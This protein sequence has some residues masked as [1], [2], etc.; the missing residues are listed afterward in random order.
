MKRP[1][2]AGFAFNGLCDSLWPF[3]TMLSPGPTAGSTRKAPV[4]SVVIAG[5]GSSLSS[6]GGPEDAATGVIRFAVILGGILALSLLGLELQRLW[7][8]NT[9]D[10][11]V[12]TGGSTG[13]LELLVFGCLG[14]AALANYRRRPGV[15]LT[16]GSLLFLA[17]GLM[18]AWFSAKMLTGPMPVGLR[19]TWNSV[20][21]LLFALLVVAPPLLHYAL[22]LFSSLVA[23]LVLAVLIVTGQAGGPHAPPQL[24]RRM[25]V[26]TSPTWICSIVAVAIIIH[27]ERERR[28]LLALAKQLATARGELQELGSYQLERRLGRGGMGEVWQASHRTL[29]RPAAIKLVSAALLRQHTGSP[30]EL[31]RTLARYQQEAKL[32]A[33]LTSAHTVQVFDYGR[34]DDGQIFYVMELLRG[35]PLSRVVERLGPQPPARVV[36]WLLEACDALAEAHSLGLVHRDLKPEN[37]F[38]TRQG[39]HREVVKVLDFGLAVVRESLGQSKAGERDDHFAGSPEFMAPELCRAGA[40]IDGR[41]DLYSLGCVAWYLLLGKPVFEGSST[42][43]I[44]K[45]HQ[46]QPLPALPTGMKADLAGLLRRLLAK[47]PEERP[48]SADALAEQ[49]RAL[50]LPTPTK[51]ILDVDETELTEDFNARPTLVRTRRK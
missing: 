35:L 51:P 41:A 17:H 30:E 11:P 28:R 29:A 27:R 15:V 26:A 4:S 25:V 37:L 12:S 48:A 49:L 23:P 6:I 24:A 46:E 9:G 38:L 1:A 2:D 18:S 22:L 7:L 14:V 3:H 10:A 50:N 33:R 13:W 20:V 19:P 45:A 31:E 44:V 5:T 32:A 16:A 40:E 34:T 43:V 36:A 8:G 42:R 21:V 47:D 39:L